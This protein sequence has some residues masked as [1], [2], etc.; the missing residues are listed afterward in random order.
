MGKNNPVSIE[1]LLHTQVLSLEASIRVLES[2]GIITREE[3]LAE[4]K[5]LQKELEEKRGRN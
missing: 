5:K 1:E 4:V 3:V 2:K